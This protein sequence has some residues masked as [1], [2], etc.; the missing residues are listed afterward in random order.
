MSYL[1][2]NKHCQVQWL[3]EKHPVTL[4]HV[5]CTGV[6]RVLIDR[7]AMAG[8]QCLLKAEPQPQVGQNTNEGLSG[9][10]CL[11]LDTCCC[12]MLLSLHWISDRPQISRKCGREQG[13][14]INRNIEEKGSDLKNL[15]EGL[16][17]KALQTVSRWS[18]P[19]GYVFIFSIAVCVRYTCK[20][21]L[22]LYMIVYWNHNTEFVTPQLFPWQL[23]TV[24]QRHCKDGSTGLIWSA[25]LVCPWIPSCWRGHMVAG[26]PAQKAL[27]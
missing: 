26:R 10:L 13:V 14:P 20:P 2:S 21:F 7:R 9:A 3:A 27:H 25:I 22:P 6:Q 12:G 17:R 5:C 19:L 18:C 4:L 16:L 8:Y 24:K 15:P 23:A 1:W 11:A